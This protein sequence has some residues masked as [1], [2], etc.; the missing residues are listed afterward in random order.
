MVD[1]DIGTLEDEDFARL[2]D[3]AMAFDG[4]AHVGGTTEAAERLAYDVRSG[5]IES[6]FS[7]IEPDD[8]RGSIRRVPHASIR[9]VSAS[10]RHYSYLLALDAAAHGHRGVTMTWSRLAHDDDKWFL[11]ED[12]P[13]IEAFNRHKAAYAPTRVDLSLLP[14]HGLAGLT[15]QSCYSNQSGRGGRRS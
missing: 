11:P 10:Q 3:R 12:R 15:L 8:L 13:H 7:W 14:S 4:Y 6:G 5:W 2:F 9:G 1:D